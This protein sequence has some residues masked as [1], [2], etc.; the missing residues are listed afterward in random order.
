MDTRHKVIASCTAALAVA[1]GVTAGTVAAA[2][3][4][5]AATVHTIR[6]ISRQ[7]ASHRLNPHTALA[8][9]TDRRAGKIVGYDVLHEHFTQT[10]GQINGAVA[11]AGGVLYFR[12]PLSN[13]PVLTGKITGGSNSFRGVRGTITGKNLN[14]AGTRTRVTITYHH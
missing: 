8:A 13:S 2:A 5:T 9:G 12:L 6:F 14:Q 10:S 3:T 7:T 1:G 11:L 4:P